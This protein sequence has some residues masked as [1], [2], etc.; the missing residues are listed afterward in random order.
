MTSN[1]VCTL[2]P[3]SQHLLKRSAHRSVG[4]SQ[5]NQSIN[6]S[7]NHVQLAVLLLLG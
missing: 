4:I 7:V 3:P 6:Q 1:T 5:G 2:S